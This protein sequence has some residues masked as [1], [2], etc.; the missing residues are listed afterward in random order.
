MPADPAPESSVPLM[1]PEVAAAALTLNP[2]PLAVETVPPAITSMATEAAT[3]VTN[4]PVC[5]RTCC[6]RVGG[7][8]PAR[9]GTSR[10]TGTGTG[11]GGG[12][13]PGA[14]V[15]RGGGG[16]GTG[17]GVGCGVGTGGV[18]TS[19][20]CR[21]R[22]G[23]R[24]R[25]APMLPKAGPSTAT[26]RP[27]MVP[28]RTACQNC[29]WSNVRRVPSRIWIRWMMASISASVSAS[30]ATA[31]SAAS[32][33]RLNSSLMTKRKMAMR[34]ASQA[35]AI[36]G[37]MKAAAKAQTNSMNIWTVDPRIMNFWYWVRIAA[38]SVVALA[39]CRCAAVLLT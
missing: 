37:L 10:P 26:T 11:G 39:L 38:F 20:S 5:W 18:G 12:T 6:G 25:S 2:W 36:P 1:A 30:V 23:T 15:G 27:A 16:A 14:G 21:G 24:F 34:A 35:I 17:F 9:T 22:T 31:P 29:A 3:S 13:G 4:S 8:V 32:I 19:V 7:A 28:S 33:R